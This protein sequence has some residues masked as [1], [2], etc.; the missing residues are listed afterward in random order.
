MSQICIY[1]ATHKKLNIDLPDIYRFCQVGAALSGRWDGYLHDDDGADNI[2]AK[3]SSYSELTA[4]YALWKNE[5]SDIKGLAHYRRFFADAVPESLEDYNCSSYDAGH[6]GRHVIGRETVT[7]Y[8]RN[9][10]V[11]LEQPDQ[12]FYVNGHEDLHRWVYDSDIDILEKVIGENFPEYAGSYAEVMSSTGLSYLNMMIAPAGIFDEYCGWLFDVLGRVEELADIST[13]DPQHKRIFGYLSE[14][15]LN[16]WVLA[17]GLKVKYSGMAYLIEDS[18]VSG[19]LRSS[20]RNILPK[21]IRSERIDSATDARERF[22]RLKNGPDAC[23]RSLRD[24]YSEFKKT[25]D[26]FAYYSRFKELRTLK[27]SFSCG[28]GS[29]T[30]V[31]LSFYDGYDLYPYPQSNRFVIANIFSEDPAKAAVI[32]AAVREKYKDG[33]TVN[34]RTLTVGAK[35]GLLTLC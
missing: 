23:M 25:D 11:I 6:I 32:S 31:I 12:P 26:I 22:L 13:Y 1:V 24:I 9:H 4:L 16:V 17:K 14:V 30:E 8:L 5:K 35:N 19:K 20:V 29:E 15:L 27:E 21:S 10:D 28:D 7:E 2:S 33:Y 3:N 34:I 18:S